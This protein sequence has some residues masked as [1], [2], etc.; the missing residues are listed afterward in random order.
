[1]KV[2]NNF[3][4]LF[5]ICMM[6]AALSLTGC[7]SVNSFVGWLLEPSDRENTRRGDGDQYAL[8]DDADDPLTEEA[9]GIGV[10]IIPSDDELASL[11]TETPHRG[12]VVGPLL[13]TKW[14][15]GT[16]YKNMLPQGHRS[17][18]NLVAATQIMKFHNHPARGRGQS[19]A[20]TMRNGALVPSLNFN[21][22]Y[23]WGNM[24]NSY[25]SDGR[26]STEQ[27]RNAVATLIYHAGVGRG[28]DFISGSNKFRWSVVLTTNFGYDKG[29][30]EHYRRF[31]TDAEW[32]AII[33]AQL[34]AGLPV[35]CNGNNQEDTSNHFFVIDGYDNTGRFHINFGWSGR[36]DGWYFLNAVNTGDREWNHNQYIVI[37]IKPDVGGVSA[38]WEMALTEFAVGKTNFSQN[39][40]FTVTTRIR[41]NGTLDS[42]PGG[43]LGVAL[44]DTNNRIIEV[45]GLRN[46][47]ALNPHSTGSSVEINC[48]VPETVRPGQYRVMA[49]IR[50]EGGNWS[51]IS[52]AAI[53]DG[54]PNAL[55]INVTAETGTPGG[56]YGIGLTAFTSNRTTV[57][58]NELF[59]V[60]YTLRNMG[61]EVF[62]G[63]QAGAALVDNS[64][65]IAAIIGTRT[66]GQRNPGGT[67]SSAT[68]ECFVP[69]TVRPGQ[70]Q[71][72]MVIRPEGVEQWRVATLSLPNV[73]T[74]INFTVTAGVAM[75]GGYGLVL[76]N[77][78]SDKTSVSHNE[79]F[80]VT[81][82][83]RNRSAE[84]F[85]GQAGAALVD[86]NGNIIAVIGTRNISLNVGNQTTSTINC[87]VPNTVSPG[88]YQLR[89]VIRPTGEEWRI[90]TLSLLDIPN[91]IAFT[92]R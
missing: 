37:N 86:N 64:G 82:R 16:P 10:I 63:G 46:R 57:P 1:M 39:E 80:A 17:F 69:E 59:T 42:F 20:Y 19:E 49:V 81:V 27:Q 3:F 52:R 74:A 88:Q 40:F 56:G 15:Q 12:A 44:V 66:P 91:S 38:G 54:I 51:V 71:L 26:D 72:R 84:R 47:A 8:E 61:T 68:M 4:A 32:E 14:G 24:L 76:E 41:N 36:H 25:R 55:N 77:F 43:Q 73:P 60:T 50:P 58:Q 89:I 31:Y 9:E 11:L 90:A 13:Q 23:D 6:A 45:I 30:R 18:C 29:I 79:Q 75:G 70:Y 85:S 21:I 62:P 7:G 83:P 33:R 53:G 35:L 87:T 34:D 2:K 28:R 65:N 5:A 78:S 67:A 48:F 92:V 22:A